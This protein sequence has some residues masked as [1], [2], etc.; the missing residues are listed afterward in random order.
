MKLFL[1]NY[2]AAM[3]V[4]LSSLLNSCVQVA[5]GVNTTANA[6]IDTGGTG[7]TTLV[8]DQ[9]PNN[10]ALTALS[11]PLNTDA[12]GTIDTAADVDFYSVATITG[13][14]YT[15]TVTPPSGSNYFIQVIDSAG[16]IVAGGINT[17]T[18]TWNAY[19]GGNYYVEVFSNGS[20]DASASYSLTAYAVSVPL[21]IVADPV[22]TPAAGTY[23]APQN[24]AVTT[25]TTGSTIRYTV[26]GTNP[27]CYSSTIYTAPVLVDTTMSIK[28]IGCQNGYTSS[29]II[30]A[31]YT[32]GQT[33][34][35]LTADI[36][37]GT[38]LTPQNIVISSTT[39]G[40]SIYY[41][42]DSSTPVCGTSTL[43][44]AA[45]INVAS[46]MT[47]KVIG[48][49]T[50]WADSA[51]LTLAYTITGT[52]AAP[53][54][55]VSGGNYN[56][57]QIVSLSS[58]TTG[59]TIY[60]TTDGI[61]VP[62]CLGTGNG[63]QYSSAI[64]VSQSAQLQ[65]IACKVSWADS[66]LTTAVYTLQPVAP[67]FS[68]AAG[69]YTSAQ[70]ITITTP[71]TGALIYYTTNGTLPVCGV[72]SLYS[73][74]PVTI[75]TNATTLLQAIACLSGWSDS[76]VASAT[77]VVTGTV[78]TP[79]ADIA[80]GTYISAQNIALS[81]ATAGASIYY[82]TDGV[83]TPV[84]GASTMYTVAGIN[85]VSTMTIK[86]VACLSGWIDSPVLTLAYII[87]GSVAAPTISPAA[88]TYNSTQF[89][90]LSTTTTGATI[91]YTTDGVTAPDCV[92]VGMNYAGSF[93][94]NQNM[95]IK[96]I[97]CKSGWSNSALTIATYTLQPLAP[98]FSI[99][100]GTYTTAQ[101]I[102]LAISTTGATIRYTVD[103]T[104]P[105]C[106]TGNLYGGVA[107]NVPL[108]TTMTINALGCVTGWSDSAIASATYTVTGTV[109]APTFSVVAGVYTSAQTVSIITSTVGASI[110]YTT[111]GVTTPT[112]TGTGALYTAPLNVALT[113][114]LKAIGC[115]TGWT[116]SAI[117]SAAYT[118]TG[119]VNTPTFGMTAG[120]YNTSFLLTITTS[121]TG[122]SI[123][124]ST[125]GV[126]VPNCTGIGTLYTGAINVNI[127]MTVKAIGCLTNWLPSTVSNSNYVMQPLA[128][129]FS[130]V[131]SAYNAAQSLTIS[132]PGGV[133]SI[134]YV[135]G[136][137]PTC[138]STLYTGAISL[139]LEN[140]YTVSAIICNNGWSNSAV[141]TKSYHIWSV[142]LH[143]PMSGN[144]GITWAP[145]APNILQDVACNGSIC[146]A[147]GTR[148]WGGASLMHSYD[149][150]AWFADYLNIML[151]VNTILYSIAWGNNQFIAVGS[152]TTT[153]TI[154]SS[155]DGLN[156]TKQSVTAGGVPLD[157][158]WSGTQ[159]VT[160]GG[161]G[162]ILT[163]S[164]GVIW[165]Q[166]VSGTT[167]MLNGI[168]FNGS[169]YVAVGN[170]G[171]ILTS[172]DGITW[173]LRTSGTTNGFTDV[174]WDGLKFIASSAVFTYTSPDGTI[175]TSGTNV[176]NAV[177]FAKN[178]T[179]VVAVD[180]TGRIFTSTNGISFTLAT[181]GTTK[182]LRNVLWTGT[183]FIAVGDNV[184]LTSN[185]GTNWTLVINNFPDNFNN[186]YTSITFNGSIYVGTGK[187]NTNAKDIIITSTDA[188]SWTKQTLTTNIGLN[189]IAYSGTSFIIAGRTGT[190][191]TSTNG[192]TWTTQTTGTTMNLT[193]VFMGNNKVLALSDTGHVI[194]STDGINWSA[195]I[196]TPISSGLT[197]GCWN[198]VQY[199]VV[200]GNGSVSNTIA[201]S[202]DGVAWTARNSN[203]G[204][205]MLNDII[206]NGVRFIAVGGKFGASGFS[207]ITT[208]TD[209][210]TW[211]A[212]NIVGT[213]MPLTSIS[214][215]G[216]RVVATGSL[217]SGS[218]GSILTSSDGL[219]WSDSGLGNT[220]IAGLNDVIFDGMKYL[221]V[222]SNNILVSP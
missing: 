97:A 138:A 116:D 4:M 16:N 81:S 110:Y 74:L 158:V 166:R 118:I 115:F 117:A 143:T 188:I 215:S 54:P 96:A 137:A 132:N 135:F 213:I 12:Q 105:T 204:L 15:A 178:A 167:S 208:S 205:N 162:R 87:T 91:S 72:S 212:Q 25:T 35:A 28:A 14:I 20:F 214:W 210:I 160:V 79:I 68:T 170:T 189:S 9:E 173:T 149:G 51:V 82:T 43:Q 62:D 176:I 124:Y 144:I 41:T 130:L 123:Y 183:Q 136:D 94:V 103:G 2:V 80:A 194:S 131:N 92:G 207:T 154:L 53:V 73:A 10:T 125:D 216:G 133:G 161:V 157:I 192:S 171:V 106:A 66:N 50:G 64:M 134:Y 174:I 86:A 77:Y 190:I 186:T 104:T 217:S 99:A 185:N 69:S 148:Q 83:S 209:G 191:L 98:T 30:A 101:S 145:V 146:V 34:A 142:G 127:S 13:S 37:A 177:K 76:T 27:N 89:V 61:T 40:A 78:A 120:T 21:G 44:T 65:A 23:Y 57:M 67:S 1:K 85:I 218:G 49:L 100:A 150:K 140:D 93:A 107:I 108:N 206:W 122:A 169:L 39:V 198:G 70:Y 55:S 153:P 84:C 42:L 90:T 181:S 17:T 139:P 5:G 165:T 18:V 151:D 29:P 109:S 164:D 184:S 172:L 102:S 95:V 180:I 24:V 119:S 187:D 45:G 38:Y 203:A 112:C 195:P 75:P 156:W 11:L 59:S 147:V 47:V 8:V 201:T 6:N 197:N 220:T 199:V 63:T 36:A 7:T 141:T 19:Q 152:G 113:T 168:T 46:S 88:G 163:S 52:V 155:P 71:T 58:S 60:Y 128:P 56:A 121:T 114:T 193:S 202:P 211:T 31:A 182:P 179:T 32:M 222:G 200:G 221:A 196:A 3:I 22:F 159:F 111:D 33:V 129:V 175:W 48:C 26:D 219:T 126:T